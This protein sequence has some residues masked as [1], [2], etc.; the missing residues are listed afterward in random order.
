M[1]YQI[2]GIG[3]KRPANWLQALRNPS[4]KRSLIEFLSKTWSDDSFAD[5]FGEK[6]LLFNNENICKRY[7]SVGRRVLTE[8]ANHL[9]CS[10]EEADTRM[11]YHLSTITNGQNVILRTN[12]T[13]CLVIGLAVTEKITQG[14]NV[15]IEAGLRSKN[16]QR[17][18]SLNQLYVKLG[19][20][21][22]RSLPGYHAFTGCDYTA[23]FCRRGKVKPL[24]IL[25]KNEKYQQMFYDVGVRP[26]L[27]D[28]MVALF[29][30]WTCKMY[31]RKKCNNVDDARLEIFLQKYKTKSLSSIKKL[32]GN[33]LPPCS[34][35]LMQ[36]MK[37]TKLITKRWLSSNEGISDPETPEGCGW[38]LDDEKNY[39]I[40]WFEGK[41]TPETI[42][43]VDAPDSEG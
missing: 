22:C 32:D 33:M 19:R 31:G 27:P 2:N 26:I 36:K 21:L 10:H 15:W 39:R 11:F 41:A 3:Q 37:R 42:D 23:S 28:A 34:R 17:Y 16:T 14:V 43:I 29:S 9:F 24:K 6:Q 40:V 4:F 30:E 13:D 20:T 8:D 12:D 18:I 25:E 7:R 35:V 5:I 38:T 1:S